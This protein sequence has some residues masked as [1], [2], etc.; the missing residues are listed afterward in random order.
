[1]DP[2]LKASWSSQI[3]T[4]F[5]AVEVVLP[6]GAL[7]LVDGGLVSFVVDGVLQSFTSRDLT[8]GALGGIDTISDG[9]AATAMS[10]RITLMP[11]SDSAIAALA[12]PEAQSSLVRVWQGAVDPATGLSIGAPER[13][14]IGS[15]DF[16]KLAISETSRQVVLQCGSDDELQLEPAAQQQLSHAFH[17]TCWPGEKGLIHIP[18]VADKVFWRLQEPRQSIVAGSGGGRSSITNSGSVVR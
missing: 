10:A 9:I 11:P 1:M 16:A 12:A 14:F 17:T 2:L 18:R 4:H 8:Y 3:S 15:L 7:R 13:L 5:T 6:G